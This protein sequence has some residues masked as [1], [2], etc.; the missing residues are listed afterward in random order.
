MPRINRTKIVVSGV[1]G[2]NKGAELMLYA[3]LKEIEA[4][5]PDAEVYLPISQFPLGLQKIN[6]SLLLRQS[7]NRF[8]RFLGKYHITGLLARLGIRSKYLY[9]L[10]PIKGAKYYL[11]ASGLFFSDQMI[12]SECIAK[13]L[14]V[15]LKGYQN[16]GTKII[17]LPQAFGPFSQKPSIN[18]VRVALEHSDLVCVRDDMSMYYLMSL[19]NHLQNIKQYYDFTGILTGIVPSEYQY[20]SGRVCLILNTQVIRKGTMG[21]ETYLNLFRCIIEEIYNNG[22]K[23]FILDHANDYELSKKCCAMVSYDIPIVS[24]LDALHIKGIISQSYLCVSSRFHGVVSSFSSCVPCLTTS[25][26]HKY[27]ELLHLYD[28]ND[29]LLSTSPVD[30][31]E[32]VN[33]YLSSEINREAREKLRSKKG[34]IN[35][36]I[37]EMWQ[38]V[39]S[40]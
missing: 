2:V 35:N 14:S 9:N 33:K 37:E 8:V 25:W 34:L 17:Y 30:C 11:D 24:G 27:Q 21:E 15:L 10:Y 31:V 23:A 5:F 19:G 12:S 16:Q 40:I 39:W 26:N 32:K 38:H 3:I 36:N 22:Y 7:P 6:T 4:R 1:E 13:D 18:A 28:M 29:V 20:L